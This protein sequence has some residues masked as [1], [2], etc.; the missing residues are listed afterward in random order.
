MTSFKV[1]PDARKSEKYHGKFIYSPVVWTSQLPIAI[2]EFMLVC[3]VLGYWG[4]GVFP[5]VGFIILMARV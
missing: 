4:T 3:G 5:R 2:P 1:P